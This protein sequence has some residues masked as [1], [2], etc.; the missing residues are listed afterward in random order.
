MIDDAFNT[1][2]EENENQKDLF[3]I[4]EIDPNKETRFKDRDCMCHLY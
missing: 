3:K 1:E 4:Y 2:E